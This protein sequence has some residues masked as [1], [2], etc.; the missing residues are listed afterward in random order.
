MR[1]KNVDK[2]LELVRT[3]F[4]YDIVFSTYCVTYLFSFII[5]IFVV[6]VVLKNAKNFG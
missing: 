1:P 5:I 6:I 3:F 2:S 4:L